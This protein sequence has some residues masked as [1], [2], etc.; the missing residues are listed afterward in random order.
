MGLALAALALALMAGGRRSTRVQ[1]QPQERP[2]PQEKPERPQ[3]PDAWG[4]IAPAVKTGGAIVGGAKALYGAVAGLAGA[5]GGFALVAGAWAVALV[6][7][8]V[9]NK[10]MRPEMDKRA[11]WPKLW[12]AEVGSL[13]WRLGR[14]MWCRLMV[15]RV[16]GIGTVQSIRWPEL[17]TGYGE[18]TVRGYLDFILRPGEPGGPAELNPVTGR[19]Y[20]SE[21]DFYGFRDWFRTRLQ[22][23]PAPAETLNLI[24]RARQAAQAYATG[25][26]F[27]AAACGR[28]A[29]ERLNDPSRC[30]NLWCDG[31]GLLG[32]AG[33]EQ[34]ASDGKSENIEE[35]SAAFLAGARD[36]VDWSRR[37]AFGFGGKP[38]LSV[39][40][41]FP[42]AE[43]VAQW[44][45]EAFGRV[46]VTETGE[47][48]MAGGRYTPFGADAPS[49]SM[50]VV[51]A[52]MKPPPSAEKVKA[53]QRPAE[54][55][56]PQNV[57][58]AVVKPP[59]EKT[60]AARKAA[61]R[62]FS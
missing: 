27:G 9:I 8:I 5:M 2:V 6:S 13:P 48:L 26:C 17:D 50:T 57:V 60:E 24:A 16:P 49:V 20:E 40:M 15:E 4:Y 58:G 61:L 36:G 25:V 10:L 46:Q 62:G 52:V 31:L 29:G 37:V 35:L 1:N 22:K 39:E 18:L 30:E 38:L 11:T 43:L 55:P 3:E 54:S 23:M 51:G 19:P 47:L 34:G 42:V 32:S 53:A 56:P 21:E 14:S 12:S 45:G 7:G 28:V 33:D 41:A 44:A 59:A